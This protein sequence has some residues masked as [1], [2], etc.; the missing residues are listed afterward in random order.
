M[1]SRK[2]RTRIGLLGVVALAITGAGVAPFAY[3]DVQDTSSDSVH[4]QLIDV[5]VLEQSSIDGLARLRTDINSEGVPAEVHEALP[6]VQEQ[7]GAAYN[8]ASWDPTS[9]R[10][11]IH[12]SG[13]LPTAGVQD[14]LEL[15]LAVVDVEFAV[16]KFDRARLTEAS[17]ALAGSTLGGAYV[18]A[19]GPNADSSGIDVLVESSSATSRRMQLPSELDGVPLSITVDEAPIAASDRN[20]DPVAPHWGGAKM[21]SPASGCTTGFGV[22]YM[23]GSV[24]RSELLSADHC[25]PTGSTWSTGYWVA[26]APSLGTMQQT[27]TVGALGQDLKRLTGA[28]WQGVIYTAGP[29]SASGLPV[30]G[31]VNPIL[32]DLYCYSGARTGQICQNRVSSMNQ[33]ICYPA[34][35]KCY[36][37]MVYTEQTSGIASA[38]Q[39]DS[40]GPVFATNNGYPLA[41]GIISG[42]LPPYTQCVGEQGRTCGD[43]GVVAPIAAFFQ[44]NPTYGILAVRP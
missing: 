2:R 4:L 13:A 40:G 7:L 18:T 5:P 9:R 3:A 29:G 33:T 36:D 14:A 38:G 41:S 35:G 12:V 31:A 28:T 6:R 25:G 16:D 32:G 10:I 1:S 21:S 8:A 37:N 23:E 22:G 17:S 34:I 27:A 20:Y 19:A 15:Q 11:T 42:V 26:N 44:A 39:G 43:K 30:T 24:L